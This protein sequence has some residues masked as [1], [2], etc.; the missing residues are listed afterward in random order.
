MCHLLIQKTEIK[1]KS[2]H[3]KSNK[4]NSTI[5]IESN[6]IE[7]NQIDDIRSHQFSQL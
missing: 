5:K 1:K 2:S 6:Q 3:I 4:S 7:L